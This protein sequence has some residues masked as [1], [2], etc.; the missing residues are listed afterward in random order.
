MLQKEVGLGGEKRFQGGVEIALNSD[1]RG[2]EA[3]KEEGEE[4]RGV[5]QWRGMLDV[6]EMEGKDGGKGGNAKLR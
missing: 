2:V 6:G 3:A 1:N 4:E 5:G